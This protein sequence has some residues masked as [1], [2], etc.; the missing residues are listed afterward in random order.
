[1]GS[2]FN[3]SLTQSNVLKYLKPNFLYFLYN[4][5]KSFPEKKY[6]VSLMAQQ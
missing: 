3:I 4:H 6:G 1:M 5:P 2:Y